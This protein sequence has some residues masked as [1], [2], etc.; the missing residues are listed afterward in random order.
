MIDKP[1]LTHIFVAEACKQ[2]PVEK[3]KEEALSPCTTTAVVKLGGSDNAVTLGDNV[4]F[5]VNYSLVSSHVF[6]S[7]NILFFF[8]S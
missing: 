1:D 4:N 6:T 7:A 8:R 3:V 2:K 5:Q